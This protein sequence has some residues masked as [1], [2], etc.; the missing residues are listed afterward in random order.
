MLAAMK[1]WWWLPVPLA[2]VLRLYDLGG[3]SFWTD[4][5]I[6]LET[7]GWSWST[8][9]QYFKVDPHP[10]LFYLIVRSFSFLGAA[11]EWS[12][13]LISVL[14]GI[15]AVCCLVWLLHR[16][17]GD[18]AALVGGLL[19]AVN[20][21]HIWVSQ[22]LRGLALAGFFLC[23]SITF[24]YTVKSD[25]EEKTS[26]HFT[27]ASLL[28]I[29]SLTAGFYTH[30]ITLIAQPVYLAY[31]KTTRKIAIFSTILF[32]PWLWFIRSQASIALSYRKMMPWWRS[33]TETILYSNAGHF[34]WHWPTF[35][36]LFEQLLIHHFRLYVVL[37]CL[38]VVPLWIL[39]VAAGRKGGPVSVWFFV[40]AA[41]MLAAARWLP[42]F[43]AKYLA[44]FL[45]FLPAA[46][47]VG[48]ARL[49]DERPLFAWSLLVLAFA[50]PL[51]NLP[52]HYTDPEFRKPA[53]RERLPEWTAGW[54]ERDAIVFYCAQ[55][56]TEVRHYL[57][58]TARLIDL[59]PEYPLPEPDALAVLRRIVPLLV[60]SGAER[61]ALVE[62]NG[63]MYPTTR[64][65]A[66]E[67]LTAQYGPPVITSLHKAMAINWLTFGPAEPAT[68]FPSGV[69]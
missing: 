60:D 12:L 26:A 50:S 69:P 49:K 44:I 28:S 2:A 58:T 25:S 59:W 32:L 64:R 65:L 35:A 67:W 5:A 68:V 47:G 61:I 63:A 57:K 7:A 45:P 16:H 3:Q 31:N 46:A 42:I 55:D 17:F 6:S 66:V 9:V 41:M 14:A 24:A 11:Q 62:L 19:V 13:R 20:P 30:Y 56:A 23:L 48:F 34:P 53:W 51:I 43:Q 36:G 29:F 33:L 21:L 39:A 18:I 4:E 15:G 10:P 8:L 1:K 38:L 52:S 37:G 27:V 54:T 40:P 22:E